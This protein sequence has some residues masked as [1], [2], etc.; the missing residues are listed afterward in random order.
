MKEKNLIHVITNGVELRIKKDDVY[1]IKKQGKSKQSIDGK[2]KYLITVCG[3]PLP[4][5]N[6]VRKRSYPVIKKLISKY[7]KTGKRIWI[8]PN[9]SEEI[10]QLK[11]KVNGLEDSLTRLYLLKKENASISTFDFRDLYY[12]LRTGSFVAAL[13]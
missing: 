4:N 3:D 13:R 8:K 1:L 5:T 12:W 7:V 2:R 9:F 10:F 6:Q 11:M